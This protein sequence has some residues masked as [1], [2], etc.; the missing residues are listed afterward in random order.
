MK[1][2]FY[3]LVAILALSLGA[4]TYVPPSNEAVV[5]N[6]LGGDKGVQDET[7]GVGWHYTGMWVDTYTFPVNYQQTYT[8]TKR[9]REDFTFGVRGGLQVGAE[10]GITYHIQPGSAPKLFQRYRKGIEEITSVQLHNMVRDAFN[11]I[12]ALNPIEYLTDGDGKTQLLN[13]VKQR[14]SEQVQ[15]YGIIVESIYWVSQP[16]LPDQIITSINNKIK[17]VQESQQKENELKSSQADAAKKVAEAEGQARSILA[18]AEAQAKANQLLAKSVSPELVEYMKAQSW[19][20]QL[21]TYM[22]SGA[23]MFFNAP[24]GR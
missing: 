7:L 3:G 12:G 18:V 13:T 19:N 15:D 10:V 16:D 22:G 17:A 2:I 20:G 11:E 4:C 23:N 6:T 1:K 14:V 5:V 21:P 9:N 8:W 24:T